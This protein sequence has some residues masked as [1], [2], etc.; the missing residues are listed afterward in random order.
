MFL[1]EVYLDFSKVLR[2]DILTVNVQLKF[3]RK[4]CI[5]GVVTNL[6]CRIQ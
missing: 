1:A 4:L 2:L 3:R 5:N 6:N